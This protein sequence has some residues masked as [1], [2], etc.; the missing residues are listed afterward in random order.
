VNSVGLGCLPGAAL[1]EPVALG[2]HF[3]DVNVMRY[4]V[5]Q[6]AGQAFAGEVRGPLLEGQV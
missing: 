2:I 3:Q 5:E 4:A 1:F 6:S